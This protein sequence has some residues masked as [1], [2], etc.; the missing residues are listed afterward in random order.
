M[1]NIDW[2]AIGINAVLMVAAMWVASIKLTRWV[3]DMKAEIIASITSHA[4]EDTNEFS[5]VREEIDATARSFGETVA[6]LKQRVNDDR[7]LAAE[8]YL[9]RDGYY[10]AHEQL[11]TMIANMRSEL[12]EDMVRLEQKLDTKT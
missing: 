7:L 4:T 9:R 12:R 5:R 11:I 2:V 8:T 6:A 10:K 3:G 1:G